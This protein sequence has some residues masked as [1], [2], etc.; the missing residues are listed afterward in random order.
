MI[1]LVFSD[2]QGRDSLSTARLTVSNRL[3]SLLLCDVNSV[4][5]GLQVVSTVILYG[6]AKSMTAEKENRDF[7]GIISYPLKPPSGANFTTEQ[8][9]CKSMVHHEPWDTSRFKCSSPESTEAVRF[10]YALVIL[11]TNV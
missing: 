6:E 3:F 1:A 7:S 11:H 2:P 8:I 4:R 10:I 5:N 9:S